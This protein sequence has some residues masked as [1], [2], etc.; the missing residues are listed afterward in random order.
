MRT[1]NRFAFPDPSD[2]RAGD[3]LRNADLT[4]FYPKVQNPSPNGAGLPSSPAASGNQGAGTG[5]KHS[6]A[7]YT[8]I[9]VGVGL[10][11]LHHNG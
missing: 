7:L 4:D 2:D 6:P 1:H 8:L 10:F 5:M 3:R 11:L 9:I